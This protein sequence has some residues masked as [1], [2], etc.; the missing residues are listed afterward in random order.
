MSIL[1]KKKVQAKEDAFSRILEDAAPE[2]EKKNKA[3]KKG[4]KLKKAV[5]ITAVVLS[6][7]LLVFCGLGL[8]GWF[9][10]NGDYNLPNVRLDGIELGG[11]TKSEAAA[12]LEEKGWDERVAGEMTVNI[13]G[14][15]S[16]ELG[17]VSSGV[18]LSAEKAVEAA[19]AQGRSN[20][21]FVTLFNYIKGNIVPHEI[22][23]GNVQV[24][25]EY[26]RGNMQRGITLMERATAASGHTVDMEKA[27]LKMVK[28]AGAIKLDEEALYAA[29]VQALKEGKAEL[30]GDEYTLPIERPDFDKLYAE[31]AVEP[32]DASFD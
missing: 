16:F 7:L 5:L 25:E 20:N 18:R 1:R 24:N 10:G 6:F 28:G 4:K 26:I 23:L 8:W 12:R 17:Y 22:D 13:P 2:T 19:Y 27:E 30:S 29:I 15:V 3:P 9:I 14:D 32:V 31:L 11:L 21:P